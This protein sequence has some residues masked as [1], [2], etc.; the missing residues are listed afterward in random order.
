MGMREWSKWLVGIAV[1]F[2]ILS[3]AQSTT[4]TALLFSR[5][6]PGGSARIQG[7][8]GVQTSLGG[9]Y[10]SA[11]SNP[12][13]LGMFNRSE[14]SISPGY[15][16]SKS[17]SDYLGN[18]KSESVSNLSVPGFGIVFQ[19]EKEGLGGFLSGAFA[20]S[21]NRTNNFNQKFSYSGRNDKNSIVDYFIEDATG[22]FPDD[23]KPG[24]DYFNS[25]TGLAYNNYLIEDSTFLNPNASELDYL[26]VLGVFP[27]NP[28][29]I[30]EVSQQEQVTFEGSQSQWSFSY[31]ANISDKVFLGAG[32]GLATL[33]FTST[34]TFQE[35]DY[36]FVLDP[37]F[38]PMDNMVLQEELRITGS[39]I[40][41]NLGIIVRPIDMVQVGISYATP[42]KY[43]LT[44]SYR[45][46]MNSVWNNFDYFGDGQVLTNVSEE[47][48][49]LISEYDLKTPGHL[50]LGATVFFQKSGFISADVEMVNYG[51]AKYSS[52]IS[53]ITFDSDNERIQELYKN[54]VNYRVGGEYRLKNLRFRA[55][56]S[57]MTDP[58]Q[59]QQNGINRKITSYSGGLGYRTQKFFLDFALVFSQGDNSYRPYRINSV[60]SPLVLLNNK[61][62]L[63][64]ITVGFPF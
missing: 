48:E 17:T 55:G 62:T 29:D 18:S 31:G 44:D 63:G 52:N 24:G 10:S 21:F 22:I 23:L 58:F 26:S 64:I 32:L 56:Y 30:R 11:F 47:T 16:T 13:G 59:T 20:I 53:G 5:I 1:F 3:L 40:N 61:S 49:E 50:N 12:A 60:D 42:T 54:T 38:N 9:D 14:A 4:E 41:A 27:N 46:S 34:K 7:M 6:K 36:L 39:G 8:G 51:G 19:S 33:R 57:F 25:P 15:I 37:G 2:P 28:N 43:N 35:S 45:A